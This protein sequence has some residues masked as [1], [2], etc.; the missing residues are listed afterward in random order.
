MRKTDI[1]KYAGTKSKNKDSVATT[2]KSFGK[3]V[4]KGLL[5][6]LTVLVITGII[7][8]ISLISFIF[9]MKDESMTYDLHKLQ[10]NY[11]S[12]IYVNGANDDSSKPVQYQSL[13][14]TENRVWVDYDKIPDAMKVAIV[15]IEDKRFWDHQGVDWRR[16]FGAVTTLFS[17]GGSYGGS[18]ITQQL[19]KNVTGENDV[20]LTRKVKEIFRALNLE[21]KY[22]KEEI[23]AA[24]LNVVNF[25]SGCN[26][27]QAA[28]NLYFGKN[29]QDCDI[30][31]CAAIAG[32]TQNP[33]KYSPLVHPDWNKERQK[34]VLDAM[35]DQGKIT[36]AEYKKAMAESE[37]MKFVGRIANASS[38]NTPIWNWY[39]DSL[40]DD[41]KN[42]LMASYNCSSDKAVDMLYH[43]G[44]KIYAAMDTNLQKIADDTF[45]SSTVF[46][47][48]TKLQAGYLAMDYSGRVLAT[49]GSR[50]VKKS[51]RLFSLA[52]ASK[53]QPGSTIKPLAIYSQGI[54]S[55]KFNYSTIVDDSPLPNW[56]G[57]GSAGPNDAD[58]KFMGKMP[59]SEALERSRNAASAQIGQ[60]ITPNTSF[61]FLKAKLDFTSLLPADNNRAPMAVGGLSEGVTVR[62]MTAGY[63]MFANGGKYYKPYT[64]YHVDDHDGNVIPGMDN[65]GEVFTQAI[66]SPT[67]SIMHHMLNT[68]I[69]GSHGTG[70]SAAISGWEVF[71]KTGTTND[72]KDSWFVGGTPFAVAGIWTGYLTP[73]KLSTL[74]QSYAKVAWKSIMTK[75][76]KD[77]KKVK[78]QYDPDVIG[79]NFCQLT[80]LL[81]N[82]QANETIQ[83]GWYSKEKMPAMCDGV[84]AGLTS[85]PASGSSSSQSGDQSGATSSDLGSGV[86]SQLPADSQAQNSAGESSNGG[87]TES[88]NPPDHS[89]VPV[90]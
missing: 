46:G 60:V 27:V 79:A 12:F 55:G 68:V 20:S 16:T 32:I 56:F 63:Q 33:S 77:K 50:G 82:P 3:L 42:G 73:A 17:S 65:R 8:S 85:S 38:T 70:H 52:T 18:T 31:E 89:I 71:G 23:L 80:G 30:A 81:A 2:T 7:V 4:M 47:S 51:N 44:L 5:T 39:V 67:A 11:T 66:S 41:V 75:Y 25:G 43:D 40:F 61:N 14:S 72:N 90:G 86:N 24:Y 34:T 19:I 15:A 36:D 83:L 74:D 59:M 54:E 13:Y 69:N 10:L 64:F 6:V 58:N 9:S 88:Q 48:N 87:P 37:N 57:D 84:H 76:L 22:S 26:G 78:F 28:A 45:E 29:I 35:H 53:R 1:S 62:E 21:K 49:V